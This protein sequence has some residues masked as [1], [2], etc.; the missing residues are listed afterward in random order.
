MYLYCQYLFLTFAFVTV[1]FA[2]SVSGLSTKNNKI[3]DTLVEDGGCL[4]TT[5]CSLATKGRASG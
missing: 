2:F 3:P 5:I 4:Q 1:T